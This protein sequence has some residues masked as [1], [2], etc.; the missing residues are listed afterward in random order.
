MKIEIFM[1]YLI[2]TPI[3]KLKQ[4]KKKIFS[5]TH[6]LSELIIILIFSNLQSNFEGLGL[7][8]YK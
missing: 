1:L 2:I 4:L 3:K 7:K 5:F 8:S 6:K